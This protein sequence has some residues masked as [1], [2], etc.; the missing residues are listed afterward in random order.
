MPY[1]YDATMIKDWQEAPLSATS[2]VVNIADVVKVTRSGR[3]FSPVSSKVMENVI[4]GK[5]AEA[6]VPVVDPVN[7]L[8]C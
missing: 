8:I 1:K 3:V 6:V 4:V 7:S 5:K 2:S